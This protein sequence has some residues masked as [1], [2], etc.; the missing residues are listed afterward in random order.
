MPDRIG[1]ETGDQGGRGLL[2]VGAAH[3]EKEGKTGVRSYAD[4]TCRGRPPPELAR[5]AAR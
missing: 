1:R 4:L 5:L 2:T 3:N